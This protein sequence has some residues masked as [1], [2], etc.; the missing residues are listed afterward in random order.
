M[1]CKGHNCDK[2]ATIEDPKDHFYCDECYKFY[3]YTQKEYWSNPDAK[4]Y[5]DKK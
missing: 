3:S 4:G 2:E 1:K 5:E